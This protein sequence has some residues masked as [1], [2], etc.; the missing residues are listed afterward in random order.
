MRV[1]PRLPAGA[2]DQTPNL[3]ELNGRNGLGASLI[4][5]VNLKRYVVVKDTSGKDLQT[6]YIMVHTRNNQPS[7]HTYTFAAPPENVKALDLQYGS[8]PTFRNVPVER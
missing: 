4:D 3:Y 8:W 2:P 5:P 1:T 6:D 7:L